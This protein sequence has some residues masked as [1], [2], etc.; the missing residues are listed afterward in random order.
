MPDVLTL[1]S[2]TVYGTAQTL[3]CTKCAGG[4]EAAAAFLLTRAPAPPTHPPTPPAARS[5]SLASLTTNTAGVVSADGGA[6]YAFAAGPDPAP[7][8]LTSPSLATLNGQGGTYW[9]TQVGRTPRE[10]PT[11]LPCPPP[12]PPPIARFLSLTFAPSSCR[13]RWT[14][15]PGT[16][17]ASRSWSRVARGRGC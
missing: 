12:H 3:T 9:T 15:P 4:G 1:N 16:C 2:G 14:R 17:S 8:M 13:A 5:G 6:S 7:G 10:R 11:A